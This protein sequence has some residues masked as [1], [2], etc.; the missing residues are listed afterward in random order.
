MTTQSKRD[1]EWLIVLVTISSPGQDAAGSGGKR[2]FQMK[3]SIIDRMRADF[4][5][6]KRDRYVLPCYLIDGT[7]TDERR[8]VQLNYVSAGQE[9]PGA[10]TDLIAKIKDAIVT[11]LDGRVAERMDDV[12]RTEAQR[13]VPGWN[14]CTFF[15]LKVRPKHSV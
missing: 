12:R 15:V 3:G 4:T 10:W 1:Q 8:C 14:F 6:A 2:L 9:D 5:L 7:F 11:T 13:A